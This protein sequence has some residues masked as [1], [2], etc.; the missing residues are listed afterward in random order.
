MARLTSFN[1]GA[2]WHCQAALLWF[3][4]QL[5]LFHAEEIRLRQND[6]TS[7][8]RIKNG[9]DIGHM[10]RDNDREFCPA[11]NQSE[12]CRQTRMVEVLLCT[13]STPDRNK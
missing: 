1:I 13:L 6:Q 7:S 10:S 9:D 8:N 4:S 12:V 5:I 11:V 3:A 2:A